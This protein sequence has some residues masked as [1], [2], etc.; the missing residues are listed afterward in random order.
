MPINTT[1]R[2][3]EPLENPAC[4]T[5]LGMKHA[6]AAKLIPDYGFPGICTGELATTITLSS[7]EKSMIRHIHEREATHG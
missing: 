5:T 4:V 3:R 2:P 6:S 1:T 7:S